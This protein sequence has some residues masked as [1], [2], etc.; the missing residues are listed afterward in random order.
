MC[1]KN[2]FFSLFYFVK[3]SINLTKINTASV[4]V[5]MFNKSKLDKKAKDF[6]FE[7]Y[8]NL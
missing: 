3:L 4:I 8:I 2:S 1:S 5:V 6:I 7:R